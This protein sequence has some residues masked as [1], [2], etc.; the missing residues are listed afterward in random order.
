L[1]KGRHATR[2]DDLEESNLLEDAGMDSE[3]PA[4]GHKY[5]V[6]FR[7]QLYFTSATSLTCLLQRGRGRFHHRLGNRHG[8][9][10]PK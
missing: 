6:A 5:L 8:K 7:V 10:G 3:F 9:G 1:N 2:H 4:I